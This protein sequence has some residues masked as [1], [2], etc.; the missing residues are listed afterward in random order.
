MGVDLENETQDAHALWMTTWIRISRRRCV[1][2]SREVR[3]VGFVSTVCRGRGRS[4][5]S[6]R[7][8]ACVGAW[9]SIIHSFVFNLNSR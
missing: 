2:R 7:R 8:V 1:A 5:V 9:I 6:C 3:V 4:C